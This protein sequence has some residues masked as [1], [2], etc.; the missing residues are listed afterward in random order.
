MLPTHPDPL[1]TVN[2]ALQSLLSRRWGLW[3]IVAAFCARGAWQIHT[4]NA[5]T[6]EGMGLWS[7]ATALFRAPVATFFCLRAR[8]VAAALYALPAM[9][10]QNAFLMAHLAASA[11]T[12]PLLSGLA[13]ELK[14]RPV[15]LPALIS[16]TCS[17]ALISA[18]GGNSICEGQLGVA[19]FAWLWLVRRKWLPAALVLGILPLVR[20][21]L[22]LL[23][24]MVTVY[25]LVTERHW[26]FAAAVCTFSL[27]YV[28]SGA[29]YHF[30]P[31]WWLHF[32][33]HPA[34][35]AWGPNGA[36]M[37]MDRASTNPASVIREMVAFSPL[38]PMAFWGTA[39]EGPGPYRV[40]A[41]YA[42]ILFV[43]LNIFP[44]IGLFNGRGARYFVVILPM[45]AIGTAR[46]L[47]DA[48]SRP[49][50]AAFR[51]PARLGLAATA[52]LA[53]VLPWTDPRGLPVPTLIWL[54]VS[55]VGLALAVTVNARKVMTL[56]VCQ[57][58]LP[59]AWV[60]AP[61]D[62]NAAEHQRT[63]EAATWLVDHGHPADGVDVYTNMHLLSLK[64]GR[65]GGAA[66][67]AKVHLLYQEDVKVVLSRL[68]NPNN[69]QR[70]AVLA[71][72]PASESGIF[73][74]DLDIA[75]VPKGSMFVFRK[76][77]RLW[78][79]LN[80]DAWAP[81]LRVVARMGQIDIMEFQ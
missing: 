26:R 46:W 78:R 6:D 43:L 76:D 15:H 61:L 9:A 58:A 8:P 66:A 39:R 31:I 63:G 7:G 55:L 51:D 2:D 79:T 38:A 22:G 1:R 77:P 25:M 37:Q 21:E 75:K 74:N 13:R 20:I 4:G 81:H 59:S 68:T 69:G 19:L 27:V 67:Q 65:L 80:H 34:Q 23:T 45:L 73:S 3:L 42:V 29:V 33:P 28:V 14:V 18:Q 12:L 44:F 10:G 41:R 32:P 35:G 48:E 24:A 50:V 30:D 36:D 5:W 52:V 56:L 72:W 11:L 54:T 70:Q 71:A 53:A 16:A 49:S 57:L 62:A 40:L 64:V 47:H 60:L 17:A